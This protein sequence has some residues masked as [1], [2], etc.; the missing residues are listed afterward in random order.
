LITK[1]ANAPETARAAL[2]K[3]IQD[4]TGIKLGEINASVH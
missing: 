4:E 2:R 3:A 1:L